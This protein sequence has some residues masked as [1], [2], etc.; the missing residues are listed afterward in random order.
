MIG[1]KK[2]F[3]SRLLRNQKYKVLARQMS[4]DHNLLLF[5]FSERSRTAIRGAVHDSTEKRHTHDHRCSL[6][7]PRPLQTSLRHLHLHFILFFAPFFSFRRGNQSRQHHP[8]GWQRRGQAK[9]G[10]ERHTGEGW[11]TS[12]I[13]RTGAF[14]L[15]ILLGGGVH[16]CL[17]PNS[18]RLR[19]LYFS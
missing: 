11:G 14:R 6:C 4:L 8:G 7:L 3:M 9:Q 16:V 13:D 5:Y 15:V 10:K 1:M 12:N 19:S 2:K 17:F 18:I